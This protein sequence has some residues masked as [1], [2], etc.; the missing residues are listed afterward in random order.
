M[1]RCSPFGKKRVCLL[2]KLLVIPDAR[3]HKN[4]TGNIVQNS[5]DFIGKVC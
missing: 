1:L 5:V 3:L 4:R 2:T